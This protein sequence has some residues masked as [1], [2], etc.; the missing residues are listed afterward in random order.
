M[1]KHKILLIDGRVVF[2]YWVDHLN[3]IEIALETE[4][5]EFCRLDGK[6]SQEE[7]NKS[8][9]KFQNNSKILVFLS[10]IGAGGVGITL[11]A[12]NNVFIME[13]G[14]NPQAE[15]QAID[16]CHRI[17]QQSPVRVIRL[18]AEDTVEVA[19]RDYAKTKLK[20]ASVVLDR[21]LV[22]REDRRGLFRQMEQVFKKRTMK[23]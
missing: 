7:R 10:T 18:I 23:I 15:E 1:T 19:I 3:L 8:I 2:T 11:T 17:G 22:K 5:I 4:G 6:M 13:P 21:N 14:W 20:L 16:R 12:A 9:Q